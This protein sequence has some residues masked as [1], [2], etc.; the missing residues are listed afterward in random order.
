MVTNKHRVF[1]SYY[2]YDDQYYKDELL[3][4]NT[5]YGLFEDYSVHQDEIDDSGKSSE[6]IRRIIRDNYIKDATVLLLLCG[7]NT[8]TRK[9]IDWE[10]HAAMFNTQNNPKMGILVV[11]L[12]GT[13]NWR[14]AGLAEDRELVS[15]GN[16][17][18]VH[19]ATR[20]DY[21]NN[22]PDMPSRIIDNFIKDVPISVADWNTI[23]NNPDT[24]RQLI[25]NAFNRKGTNNYDHSTPLKGRNSTY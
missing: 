1:I 21:E 25:D 19:L 4:Q 15:P 9:H 5:Q 11:N 3:R 8:K 12:P 14:R 13:S 7:K 6:D 2:H 10:L 18:W 23:D 16:C 22:Y 20:A 17:N 24:I